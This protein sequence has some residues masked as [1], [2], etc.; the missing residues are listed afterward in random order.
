MLHALVHKECA[1]SKHTVAQLGTVLLYICMAR[2]DMS[3]PSGPS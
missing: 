2:E 3:E 1:K